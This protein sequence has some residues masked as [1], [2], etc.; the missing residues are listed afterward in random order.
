VTLGPQQ[1]QVEDRVAKFV[2]RYAR[3]TTR[4]PTHVV[5]FREDFELVAR[6]RMRVLVAEQFHEVLLQSGP[7]REEY[8]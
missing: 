6:R 5:L 4:V 7:S 2:Q 1:A 3:F 8:V